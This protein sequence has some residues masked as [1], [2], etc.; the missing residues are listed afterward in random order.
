VEEEGY[1]V[2]ENWLRWVFLQRDRQIL[3]DWSSGWSFWFPKYVLIEP[4]LSG[5]VY[6]CLRKVELLQDTSFTY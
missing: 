5:G 6:W 3:I 1:E 4:W 2:D